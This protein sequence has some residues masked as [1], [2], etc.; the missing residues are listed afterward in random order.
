MKPRQIRKHILA[1]HAFL[2]AMLDELDQKAFRVLE[3]WEDES[4]ALRDWGLSFHSKFAEHLAFEVR[5]L[6]PAGAIPPGCCR[7][8][9]AYR[10]TEQYC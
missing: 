5:F 10:K 9:T 7:R 4:S 1:V 8:T 3:G 6:A 2:R